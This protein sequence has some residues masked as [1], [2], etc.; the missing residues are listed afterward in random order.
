MKNS[1]LRPPAGVGWI[2]E[3][4]HDGFRLLAR[5]DARRRELAHNP[6]PAGVRIMSSVDHQQLFRSHLLHAKQYFEAG[7]ATNDTR[8]SIAAFDSMLFECA[9]ARRIA[10]D[11]PETVNTIGVDATEFLGVM[12]EVAA[13]RNIMEHWG[14]VI[15]PRAQKMHTHTSKAGLKIALDESSTIILGPEEIYKG[16][17][18]L[19]DVYTYLVAKL[20]QIG[21]RSR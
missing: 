20:E 17:L 9:R 13:H 8:A 12:D 3:I 21:E 4:K 11:A 10:R 2:H 16:N 1:S 14:E 18:N 15:N 5:R 7:R 19:H 6:L